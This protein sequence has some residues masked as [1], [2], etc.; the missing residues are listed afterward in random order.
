[1]DGQIRGL[2]EGFY[3]TPWSW[4]ARV[5]VMRWC[6]QRGMTHYVY[7]PKDDPKHRDSWR[8]PY[9][10][11][12]LDG[13]SRLL[14]EG[15][16]GVGFAISP[17][18]SI[19]YAS[20]DDRAALAAKVDQV[21]GLGIDLIVLALD[22]IPFRDGLGVDHARLTT[23]LHEHLAGR[24]SL[25]LVP[26]EYVGVRHTPYLDAVA[27]GV[28]A[29]VP[30]GWTGVS[31]VNDEITADDARARAAALGGRA[32][33]LWDN[34]PVNDGIM[35]DR[36]FL[37]PLWGRDPELVDL[38]SGYLANPMVQP[39]ASRLPLASIAAW[40]RGEDP[41]TAWAKEAEQL[42]WRV[43]AEACDGAV[44]NALVQEVIRGGD[45]DAL[46]TW[47]EEASRC[48]APGL[49]D[50]AGPWLEQVHAEAQIGTSALRALGAARVEDVEH[51]LYGAFAL[52]AQWPAVRRG[53]VSVM[54]PRCSFRPVLG[55]RVDGRWVFDTASLTEDAN[56]IDALVRHAL[57]AAA[58]LHD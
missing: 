9:G 54:G 29:D 56:A 37:G 28:P 16:L 25:L 55:Q 32:P 1:M 26:T 52:A 15:G 41:V 6:H 50:E 34:F 58:T 21:V 42:G 11:E 27:E 46:A 30:I 20:A 5:D 31:V 8:E 51:A 44:P 57:S 2:I 47:L 39:M 7:A 18:L 22:D 36:M 12:T 14:A 43:F 19:D 13:F 48:E 4:D 53:A 17:G 10:A 38:C 3:G 49:E 35:V 24:A 45:V 23:W 33:L 40:L